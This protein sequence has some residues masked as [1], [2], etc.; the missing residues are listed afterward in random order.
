MKLNFKN[1][2]FNAIA[3][4]L[5]ASVIAT[6][7]GG[8]PVVTALVIFGGGCLLPAQPA[9]AKFSLAFAGVQQ[10]IWVDTIEEN[11]YADNQFMM[12]SRD[13]GAFLEGRTVKLN[14][15]G[16][17]P[18]VKKNRVSLPATATKREDTTADYDID[19]YTTD[20]IVIGKTEEI[21]SN[22][23]KRQ[24]VLFDHTEILKESV[25]EGMAYVWSPSIGVNIIRTTGAGRDPYKIFQLGAGK[26]ARRRILAADINRAAAILNSQNVPQG[27]RYMLIDSM[28]VQDLLA[29]E[30]YTSLE[31][32]GKAVLV[33]GAIGK[34]GGFTVFVRSSTVVY[35]NDDNTKMDFSEAT[36]SNDNISTLFWHKNYVRRCFGGS[37]NGGIEVFEDAGSNGNGNP[38]FF[39]TVI[40]ALVR[41]GGR[42][43][44][45]D[46]R[47]IVALV[48]DHA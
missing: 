10:A 46:E 45:T 6:Y 39:G 47:G 3:A 22:Y 4:L 48:E 1:L 25:A 20:P 15:A 29:I 36:S 11:I 40:S 21:E 37:T 2:L 23:D 19:E 38:L 41:S 18:G 16:N 26:V 31:K 33:E 30:E 42:A 32:I 7:L 24:S 27:D 13:D 35:D 8:S 28:L 5:L 9:N 43:A 17:K 34:V 12:Q 44:R 14:Q